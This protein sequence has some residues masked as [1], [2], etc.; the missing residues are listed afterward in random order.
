MITYVAG[1]L[2]T[3]PAQVLVNTVNT[4][5]VMGKGIALEFK[6]TFPEMFEQYQAHCEA[7]RIQIGKLWIYKTPNKWIL[8]FPTKKSW[9]KPS[10]PE[11]I[12]LGLQKLVD[13]FGRLGIHSIAFP[14]LGCGNGELDWTKTVKPILEAHLNKLPADV[15]VY[16]PLPSHIRPEHRDQAQIKNWLRSEPRTLSFAE[17]W[18]DLLSILRTK[19]TFTTSQGSEFFVSV[20]GSDVSGLKIQLGKRSYFIPFQQLVELWQHLRRHGYLRR[21]VIPDEMDVTFSYIMPIFAQL[22]YIDSVV[23]SESGDFSDRAV[24]PGTYLGLQYTPLAIPEQR[25]MFLSF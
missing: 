16:P 4:E 10:K 3:S 11:Y 23:L 21:G 6:K 22:E 8:N 9:R 15:F 13:R 19:S 2:F 12:E 25:D 20:S 7:G 5:G 17:V 24:R 14:A 18:Q 1:N